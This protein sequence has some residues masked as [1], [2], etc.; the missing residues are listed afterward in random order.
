[1]ENTHDYHEQERI[2][3]GFLIL[4]GCAVIFH[5]MLLDFG[6]SKDDDGV[7]DE[8]LAQF[9][10]ETEDDLSDMDDPNRADPDVRLISR[11]EKAMNS[12]LPIGAAKDARRTQL[13]NYIREHAYMSSDD[14]MEDSS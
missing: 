14:E 6:D 4:I 1:M 2:F 12:P 11:E 7:E 10:A 13:M 9:F 3:E 8:W 5:N